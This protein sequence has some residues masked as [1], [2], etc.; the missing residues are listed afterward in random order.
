MSFCVCCC[1]LL[2]IRVCLLVFPDFLH[3]IEPNSILWRSLTK[4][5]RNPNFVEVLCLTRSHLLDLQCKFKMCVGALFMKQQT[6]LHILSYSAGVSGSH[7]NPTA[8]QEKSHNRIL[9]ETFSTTILCAFAC[10]IWNSVARHGNVEYIEFTW[11]KQKLEIP[12]STQRLVA[13][14]RVCLACRCCYFANFA[15]WNF[16]FC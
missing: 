3:V 14:T 2:F 11:L 15:F 1:W 4:Y 12:P 10:F 13:C 16:S 8:T 9:C 6:E 5:M 7:S